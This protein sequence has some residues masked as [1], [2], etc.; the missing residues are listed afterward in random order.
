LTNLYPL[1]F[2]PILKEKIWGG[3]ALN[4]KVEKVKSDQKIGE[5]WELSGVEGS[6]SIVENG[7][8]KGESLN[9]ILST[10]GQDLLG[11]SNY[12]RFG[13]EFPL[14][15]KFIDAKENLS[16]QLHPDDTIA[17]AKHNCMGKTEMWYIMKSE[18][19]FI[20]ADFKGEITKHDYIKKVEENSLKD[21]LKYVDVQPGDAYFIAPGLIHAIGEGVM[22]AEI[23]QTSDITYRIY[24]WDRVDDQ[25]NSRE[26]HQQEALDAID[27]TRK[28]PKTEYAKEK[29]TLNKVVHNTYFKTDYLPVDGKC[30]LDLSQKD[31]FTILINI[32][33]DAE[34]NYDHKT[35]TFRNS[36]TY[37]IPAVISELV[38]HA[39]QG[40]FLTVHI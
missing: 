39:N 14:L 35:Y 8:L 40:K 31:S 29:N 28:Q 17:R 3:H 38:L 24:D 20:I 15:I 5:S 30:K 32:G 27:F 22:L 23:Q 26:L 37:L 12:K 36:E 11:I 9:T 2:A 4:Y 21:A 34:L 7:E 25:G 6:V 18:D 10:Y 1:K 13:N 19:G 16:V 33:P